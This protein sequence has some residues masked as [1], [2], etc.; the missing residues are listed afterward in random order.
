M[1]NISSD[2]FFLNAQRIDSN[3]SEGAF[4]DFIDEQL[5]DM[6]EDI[7]T[8]GDLDGR[9]SD[10]IIELDD[11]RPPTF[12]YGNNEDGGQGR[13]QNGPGEGSEKVRFTLPLDRLMEMIA[14]KLGLPDLKKEGQGKIKEVSYEFKTFGTAGVILDRKRTFKRAIRS[15]IGTGL[16]Q[17]DKQAYDVLIRRRDRRYKLPER[18]ER[19]KYRAVVFYMGDISYS[20]FGE[21]LKL[22]K[23]VVSFI[24]HWLNYNYG[25]GNVEHRFFVH[26]STAHEVP[27]DDFFNVQNAGG[28]Q[29]APVFDLVGNIAFNEYDVEST[30]FYGFYFGDGELFSNDANDIV[31]LLDNQIFASFNRVGIVEVKPGSISNLV[32][33]LREQFTDNPR[34]RMDKLE[35]KQGILKSIKY[36]FGS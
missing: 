17:P 21:R 28:T 11:I 36:L 35:N 19:P 15:A 4:N 31:K 23:R 22:E 34:I 16:Y 2:S 6:V 7:L 26:D 30:N 12:T 32:D 24:H 1:K 14:Q 13:G 33:R 10:I 25:L 29:A 18:I 9:S 8:D 27:E 3:E 20:T 5:K